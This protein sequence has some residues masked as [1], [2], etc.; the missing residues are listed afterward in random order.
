MDTRPAQ[1][2]LGGLGDR[3]V[4][5]Q[6][7]HEPRAGLEGRRAAEHERVGLEQLTEAAVLEKIGE[8]I[9]PHRRYEQCTVALELLRR[10][11]YELQERALLRRA[12]AL[13]SHLLELVHAEHDPAFRHEPAEQMTERLGLDSLRIIRQQLTDLL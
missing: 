6:P 11:G 13:R 5:D 12:V 10:R 1:G 9:G 7:E 2:H 3:P 8:L 4:L